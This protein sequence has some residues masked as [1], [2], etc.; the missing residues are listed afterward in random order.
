[1]SRGYKTQ[2]YRG[3]KHTFSNGS[4]CA[5]HMCEFEVL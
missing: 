4:T 5:D 3:S 1:M 2:E